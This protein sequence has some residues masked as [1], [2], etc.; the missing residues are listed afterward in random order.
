MQANEQVH[1]KTPSLSKYS[2]FHSIRHLEAIEGLFLGNGE[3]VTHPND[4]A[5]SWPAAVIW[6]WR[7]SQPCVSSCPAGVPP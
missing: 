5:F 2:P 6:G 4:N 7:D 3:H 1:F